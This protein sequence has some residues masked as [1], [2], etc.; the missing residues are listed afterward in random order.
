MP[1]LPLHAIGRRLPLSV[2]LMNVSI[3]IGQH[4]RHVLQ[5]RLPPNDTTQETLCSE[6]AE[7]LLTS[8][9]TGAMH[10]PVD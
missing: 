8:R 6:V 9:Q 5:R 3:L 2:S 10:V 7:I 4:N 1:Q